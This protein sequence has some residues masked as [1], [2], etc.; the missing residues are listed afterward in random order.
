MNFKKGLLRL[1]I[2]LSIIW[3]ASFIILMIVNEE[4]HDFVVYLLPISLPFIIPLVLFLI[5]LPIFKYLIKP[6]LLWLV[7]GFKN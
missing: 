1:Y 7:N 5:I 6:I 3:I 2:F 4:Y